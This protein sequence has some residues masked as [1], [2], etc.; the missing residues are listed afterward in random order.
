MELEPD[1]DDQAFR[2]DVRGFIQENLPPDMA[3]RRQRSG[4]NAFKMHDDMLAW[5]AM[6]HRRGWS[7]P[8][9]PVEHGGTAWTPMQH[10]IFQEELWA[11][12]CPSQNVQGINLVGPIVYLFGDDRQKAEI[13]PGIREGT[14]YW[15]QG[16]SEPGAG[17]DLASLRTAAVRS[18]DR[19]IVNG[20]KI[21]TSGAHESDWGFFL[22]R[23]DSSGRKQEGI[24]FLLIR[25]D[26]P[27]ITVRRIPAI[28]GDAHLCEVFL[29]NVEVP[30]E[31]LVGE[32]GRGWAY[33]KALLDLERVDSS[34]IFATMREIQRLKIIAGREGLHQDDHRSRRL[35]AR[36]AHVEAQ[37]KA[38]EWS[39]LRVLGREERP[40]GATPIAS[41]LKLR[42]A[43]LQQSITGLEVDIL[44]PKALRAFSHDDLARWADPDDPFWHDEIPGRTFSMLYCRAATIFGGARQ[45]QSNIIAKSAFDL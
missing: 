43:E 12:D 5:T 18:G 36:I 34:F 14:E 19:W 27:G 40:Y 25:M 11:A 1:A 8:H 2:A 16:F 26:T 38:L 28:H 33:A 20:Q 37:A 17:S 7:V 31:N 21:W 3:A 6:L 39:V 42:G 32:A 23:T 44:G 41:A 22:V 15:C 13:L 4:Y 9:W 35:L 29:D 10:F 24:S 45:I 30:A